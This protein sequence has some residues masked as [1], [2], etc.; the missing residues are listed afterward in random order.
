MD[1]LLLL[2][3]FQTEHTINIY[4]KGSLDEQHYSLETLS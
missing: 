1:S 3:Y 4:Q 2:K